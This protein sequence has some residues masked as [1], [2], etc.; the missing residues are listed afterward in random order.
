MKKI[1]VISSSLRLNSNSEIL[2]DSFI[3]GAKEKGNEVTKICLKN[4][5]LLFCCGCLSCQKNGRC[6]QDD[7]VNGVLDVIQEADILV[8]AT[9]IYYYSVSGQLKTF[10]DR[11]NPLYVRKNSFKEIY[12]IATSAEK[13]KSAMDGAI[14][15]I[16]NWAGCFN[17]TKL[18]KVFY[19]T[20]FNKP[21]ESMNTEIYQECL[22]SGREI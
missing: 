19:G 6:F 18:T 8:F 7:F 22:E 4:Q 5:K 21:G 15:E 2:A 12:L 16:E 17:G 3:R 1:V 9:P 11:L 13:E 14:K 10:L 20:G